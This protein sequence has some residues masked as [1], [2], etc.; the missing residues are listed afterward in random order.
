MKKKQFSRILLVMC[1]CV[2]AYAFLLPLYLC[3]LPALK[4]WRIHDI[5]HTASKNLDAGKL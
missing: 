4:G 3:S 1:A 5:L 2:L